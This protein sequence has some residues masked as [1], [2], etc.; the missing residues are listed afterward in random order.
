MALQ[1][2]INDFTYYNSE[3]DDAESYP[4]SDPKVATH[5]SDGKKGKVAD[6]DT[7]NRN[8]QQNLL[9][10]QLI[11]E[12]ISVVILSIHRQ[13]SMGL[14]KVEILCMRYVRLCQR[15]SS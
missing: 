6:T 3:E 10:N 2:T 13:K 4:N 14:Q 1:S 12:I 15:I 9:I 8:Y 5:I 11:P 7:T